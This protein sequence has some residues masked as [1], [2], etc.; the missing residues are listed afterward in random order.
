MDYAIVSGTTVTAPC[1]IGSPGSVPGWSG[2]TVSELTDDDVREI[3]AFG[4][5]GGWTAGLIDGR[6]RGAAGR[7]NPFALTFLSGVPH[8]IWHMAYK[9]GVGLARTWLRGGARLA[10][11]AQ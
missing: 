3:C 7:L 6:R 2:K 4:E 8:V 11:E 5:R 9:N 10:A 1:V